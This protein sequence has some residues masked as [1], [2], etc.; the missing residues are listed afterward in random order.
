[1]IVCVKSANSSLRKISSRILHPLDDP[2][3]G[4]SSSLPVPR[5]FIPRDLKSA[6]LCWYWYML[7]LIL[8]QYSQTA[9]QLSAITRKYSQ[10]SVRELSFSSACSRIEFANLFAKFANSF[11]NSFSKQRRLSYSDLCVYYQ[12]SLLFG[13]SKESNLHTEH[14][15]VIITNIQGSVF[16]KWV[17]ERR[18]LIREHGLE[19]YANDHLVRE[20][21]PLA[22]YFANSSGKP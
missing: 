12:G 6:R 22:N 16:A 14:H 18:E 7:I 4:M 11:A 1:M 3:A 21:R 8:W 2:Q 15:V 9:S 20:L 19:M 5:W 10:T 13:Q 17:C